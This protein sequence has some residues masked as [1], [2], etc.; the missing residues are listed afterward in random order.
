M[1]PMN[2]KM[3]CTLLQSPARDIQGGKKRW[4]KW[5]PELLLWDPA[6]VLQDP[7]NRTS[8]CPESAAGC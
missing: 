7:G 6:K 4:T 1:D 2:V 8:S 5:D 3:T